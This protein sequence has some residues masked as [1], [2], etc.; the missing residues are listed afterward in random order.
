MSVLYHPSK[1]NVVEDALS[2]L[3]MD[4]L[5][6]VEGC[7][8]QAS[9]RQY[10]SIWVIVDQIKKL[11]HFI[12]VKGS[13]SME[14]YDIMYL[15]EMVRF[16]GVPLSIISDR[17]SQSISQ[18]WMSF[19]M[20]L[21]TC[22]KLTTAYHP[23]T[24]GHADRTIQTLKDILRDCVIDFEADHLTSLV[25]ITDQLSDSPFGVVHR[26][27]TV[28]FSIIVLWVIGRHGTALRNFSAIRRL[29]P[30]TADLIIFFIPFCD[31]V[32]MLYFKL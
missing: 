28:A 23:Q 10:D 8:C 32:S 24:Y 30:L 21:C 9:R 6:H 17:G 3:S 1:V 5:A 26:R 27:L 20:G 7:K 4:S 19:Q 31:V 29:L 14:D 25:K 13:Y 2:R 12:P 11:D 18:F 15:R 22:V 16:H